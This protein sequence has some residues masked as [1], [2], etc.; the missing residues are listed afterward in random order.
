MRTHLKKILIGAG[1]VIAVAAVSFSGAANTAC[2]WTGYNWNCASPRVYYQPYT[3]QYG[4]QPYYGYSQPNSYG[5]YS[6]WNPSRYPG[7]SAGGHG[8]YQTPLNL[9]A[10]PLCPSREGR[11]GQVLC[12]FQQ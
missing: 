8:G 5:S 7:P 2:Y 12:R 11:G 9:A 4:Y 10:R 3:Y 1:A 6:Y